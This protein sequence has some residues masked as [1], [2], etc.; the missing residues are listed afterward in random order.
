MTSHYLRSTLLST[1]VL[2]ATLLGGCSGIPTPPPEVASITLT[3]VNSHQVSLW[4][5]WFEKRQNR[6]FLTGHVFR[7]YPGAYVDTSKTH[8]TVTLFNNAG[9]CLLELPAEFTPSMIPHGRRMPGYSVFSIPLDRLPEDTKSI[10]IRAYDD[11][12]T[13]PPA[14]AQPSAPPS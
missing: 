8:L 14:R 4:N 9:K 7:H 1:S 2:L 5:T 6:L 12:E 13:T 10:Q 3:K 11:I